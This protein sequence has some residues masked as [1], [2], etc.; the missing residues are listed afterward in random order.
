MN[1]RSLISIYMKNGIQIN[2]E[3]YTYVFWKFLFKTIK[4]LHDKT[5]GCLNFIIQRPMNLK[6]GCV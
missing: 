5:V 4:E 3:R 2:D 6:L 1:V